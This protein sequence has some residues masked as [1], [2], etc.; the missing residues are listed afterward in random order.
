[1]YTYKNV[2]QPRKRSL[3]NACVNLPNGL[4]IRFFVSLLI[5]HTVLINHTALINHIV[6]IDHIVLI[7]HIVL[8]KFILLLCHILDLTKKTCTEPK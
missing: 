3:F 6:L 4:N 2:Y 7:N 1:M 5:N 8:S